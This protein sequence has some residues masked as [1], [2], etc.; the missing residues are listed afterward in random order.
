MLMYI[1]LYVMLAYLM[2]FAAL[3][4]D[5]CLHNAFFLFLPLIFANAFLMLFIDI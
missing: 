4:N 3:S 5:V 1:M 2:M